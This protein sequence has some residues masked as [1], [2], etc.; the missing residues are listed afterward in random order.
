[1]IEVDNFVKNAE[2]H[3]FINKKVVVIFLTN[4]YKKLYMLIDKV[5]T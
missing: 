5:Y 4:S 3:I 2:M 1:M